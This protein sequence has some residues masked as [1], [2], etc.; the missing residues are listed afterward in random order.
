MKIT[1]LIMAAVCLGSSAFTAH[2]APQ[3]QTNGSWHRF[4][5][6][7][8]DGTLVDL[9][10]GLALIHGKNSNTFIGLDSMSDEELDRVDHFLATR[11]AGTTP[12]KES[13]SEVWTDL[14]GK[15]KSVQNGKVRAYDPVG[16]TEPELY[17][18]YFSA[19]WCPPCHRFTP[20]LVEAYHRIQQRWPGLVEVVLIS[21]DETAW[22]AE[23]YMIDAHMP[24]LML[25]FNTQARALTQWA[26]RGIPCLVAVS[27]SGDALFHSYQGETYL[28]PESVLE[29]CEQLLPSLDTRSPAWLRARH[30]LAVRHH[31]V[32]TGD[33]S[34]KVKP[35]LLQVDQA[36]TEF[37]PEKG[38][39][40]VVEVD[41]E[42]KV[43][44]VSVEGQ[45]YSPLCD[46]LKPDTSNWL[47][48]PAIDHGKP[49]KATVK[50]PLAKAAPAALGKA[51]GTR[52]AGTVAQ[53]ASLQ[54]GS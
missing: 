51:D 45:P 28:G 25:R 38:V 14:K 50:V 7:V 6:A 43:A 44:D 4:D 21:S 19:S 35:Y 34:S 2:A 54:A 20:Q 13:K 30:R 3:D 8:V 17:L 24:W 10:G 1:P 15:L 53:S 52:R 47:F 5:G 9:F 31:R 40:M 37:I 41:E 16:R 32:Q 29:K 49:V 46:L 39:L 36:R 26:A 48:L 33:N 23:K 22:D 27:R 18:A 12:W 42:G 11:P